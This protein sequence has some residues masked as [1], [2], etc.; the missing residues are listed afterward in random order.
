VRT[1]LPRQGE[2]SRHSIIWRS[3]PRAR[4]SH[5]RL[6]HSNNDVEIGGRHKNETY[7]AFSI[8][9][10]AGCKDYARLPNGISA[11]HE[12]GQ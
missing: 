3:R 11:V 8:H 9:E 7:Q 2:D 1:L 12:G 4:A 6:R 10:L 5:G